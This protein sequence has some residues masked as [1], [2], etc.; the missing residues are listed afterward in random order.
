MK[1]FYVFALALMSFIYAF[2]DEPI[3]Q[4]FGKSYKVNNG[5]GI[6]QFVKS[7]NILSD[8]FRE[9]EMFDK[10]NG[11]FN[12]SEEGS[13]Y[14]R[15]TVSYWN[16]KDGKKL[17]IVSFRHSD[18]VPSAKKDEVSSQ[19]GYRNFTNL[20]D[21]S[22]YMMLTETGF[23]AYL[24]DEAT[25]QL[26]SLN[27]PPFNGWKPQESF[28][29]IL[30]L[31]QTGKNI[32]VNQ[33]CNGEYDEVYGTLFWNGMTFDFVK[34]DSPLLDLYRIDKDGEKTNIRNAPNG[35]IVDSLKPDGI[36]NMYID[37][38]QNGWCHIYND[39]VWEIDKETPTQLKGSSNG[40]WIHNSVIGASGLGAGGVTL[41]ATPSDKS[42]VVFKSTDYTTIHPVEI[43]GEWVKVYVGSSKT[44]GWMKISDICS[45]P[46]TNCC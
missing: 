33:R 8:E 40:Y 20:E 31:P 36:Y 7:L 5:I 37:N 17:L 27:T 1:R 45:N 41:Y 22:E 13:G 4:T 43:K 32:K 19:W 9:D 35:K 26:N 6:E 15:Y 30:E 23:R 29:R 14:I 38:I 3:W 28:H 18:F 12:F 25:K 2:A 10:K 44:Q 39:E 24:Y 21:D 16:R 42:K 11:Y 34:I 46:V